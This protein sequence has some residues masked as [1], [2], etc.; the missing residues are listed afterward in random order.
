MYNGF[1]WVTWAH[2]GTTLGL[3]ICLGVSLDFSPGIEVFL[4]GS[5]TK[6]GDGLVLGVIAIY[7]FLSSANEGVQRDQWRETLRGHD[8]YVFTQ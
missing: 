8:F 1:D 2:L 4:G 6:Q 3:Q 5:K 7:C